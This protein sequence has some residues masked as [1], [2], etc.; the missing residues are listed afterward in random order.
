MK[1]IVAA[2]AACIC[3]AGIAQAQTPTDRELEQARAAMLQ[4]EAQFYMLAAQRLQAELAEKERWWI[5]CVRDK[6]CAAWA[7]SG[8]DEAAPQAQAA[9]K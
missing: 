9:E 3:A 1:R 8:N 6:A 7:G 4:S 5:A 2:A